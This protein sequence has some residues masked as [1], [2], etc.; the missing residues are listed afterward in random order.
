MTL[1]IAWKSRDG[2]ILGADTEFTGGGYSK[3]KGKKILGFPEL[4]TQPFFAFAGMVDYSMMCIH[5]LA[6]VIGKEEE[7]AAPDVPA[8]I[9]RE[10]VRIHKEYGPLYP[11]DPLTLQLLIVLRHPGA[12]LALFKVWGPVM[13]PI[14]D[15]GV[16]CIGVGE[17]VSRLV[18]DRFYR[19]EMTTPQAD[20]AVMYTLFKAKEFVGGVGKDSEIV[21]F[22]DGE[23]KFGCLPVHGESITKFQET[24]SMFD[25]A[26]RD[27]L[28]N[29]NAVEE[30]EELFAH[31]LKVFSETLI[32]ARAGQIEEWKRPNVRIDLPD[33][34]V[35][36]DH[37]EG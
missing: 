27:I 17:T 37:D 11:D 19:E 14:P 25:E 5:R 21:F 22:R 24:L 20:R 26:A 8:V 9:E 10:L 28:L 13:A 12:K 30:D 33:F 3:Y 7:E 2:A 18:I 31:R 16:E 6:K 32:K 15:N 35:I 23:A 29:Y 4:R 36:E 1:A 34:K